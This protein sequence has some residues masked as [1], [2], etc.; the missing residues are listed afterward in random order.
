MSSMFLDGEHNL[1]ACV[2]CGNLLMGALNLGQWQTECHLQTYFASADQVRDL[3]PVAV[4]KQVD[5]QRA[6]GQEGSTLVV[7]FSRL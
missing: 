4:T 6:N 2:A 1:A 3:K 5:R 7:A